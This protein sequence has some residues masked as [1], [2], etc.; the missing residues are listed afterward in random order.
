MGTGGVADMEKLLAEHRFILMEAAV[1]EPLR[2][3]DDSE[4]H[5]ELVN[6]PLIY[7]DRGRRMLTGIY[8]EYIDIARKADLPLIICSPTWRASQ[9]RVSASGASSTINADAVRFLQDLRNQQGDFQG[10]LK[11]AG[12]LGCRN[13]AYQPDAGLCPEEAE[14]FH[15]WQIRELAGAGA[16]FLFAVTLPGV[17]E[18]LGMARAM[19]ATQLPYIVSFVINRR[20]RILD[21]T[22]LAEAIRTIDSRVSRP[23]L[24]YLINCAWPGFLCAPVRSG[25]A[26]KRLIGYQ[27][28][29]SSLDHDELDN[30]VDLEAEDIG[31]WAEEMVRLN[32]DC[33]LKILGGC[34]GTDRRHLQYLVDRLTG[35]SPSRSADR[36]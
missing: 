12:M 13:D 16:D 5:P 31:V 1:V 7:S 21:G 11:I 9:E 35:N 30:A 19:A 29:A 15:A 22:G 32:Q 17:Q 14:A 4:L 28:N 24:G 6:A 27:A 36:C 26:F 8:Q 3:S 25:P 2:R 20:G 33:G 18:A 23:P 10:K 34:C